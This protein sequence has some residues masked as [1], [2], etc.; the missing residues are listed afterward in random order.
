MNRRRL[1]VNALRASAGLACLPAIRLEA[2]AH[3]AK[4]PEARTAAR[5]SSVT[6]NSPPQLV[7]HWKLNGDCQDA[8]GNHH[9]N[10]RGLAFGEGVDG[11]AGGAAVF[12]GVESV[13]EVPDA[14]D[15]NFG[16][17]PLCISLSLKLK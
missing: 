6:V 5:P 11:R 16:T 12:N 1:L 2:A 13:I 9:G 7:A 10:A 14:D 15:L 3:L 8:S 4:A 17:E